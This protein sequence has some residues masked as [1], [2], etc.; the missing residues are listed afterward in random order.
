PPSGEKLGSDIDLYSVKS[1]GLTG[2]RTPIEPRGGILC[3]PAAQSECSGHSASILAPA[4]VP[5]RSAPALIISRDSP[6]VCMPPAAFT[7]AVPASALFR[8]ATSLV[9]APPGPNPV[10]VF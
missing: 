4:L 8:M 7:L 1:A 10:D 9:V 5:S 6:R 3:F 2:L